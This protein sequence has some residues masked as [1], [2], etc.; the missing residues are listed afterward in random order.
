MPKFN[1]QV[2]QLNRGQTYNIWCHQSH[3][4]KHNGDGDMELQGKPNGKTIPKEKITMGKPSPMKQIH[5]SDKSFTFR[6]KTFS[7]T[8]RV[9]ENLQQKPFTELEY[10]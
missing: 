7:Q 10:L 1:S 3:E 8:L 6:G 4:I 5:Y 9:I 2:A